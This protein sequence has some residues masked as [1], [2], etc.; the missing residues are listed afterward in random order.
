M[1]NN[2]TIGTLSAIVQ[3]K[4]NTN[5]TEYEDYLT[6]TLLIEQS[7]IHKNHLLL[8]QSGMEKNYPQIDPFML[9]IIVI[10][11]ALLFVISNMFSLSMRERVKEIGILKA[12]GGTFLKI[13]LSLISE[14]FVIGIIAVPLGAVLGILLSWIIVQIS[15]S[16]DLNICF[17]IPWIKISVVLILSFSSLIISVLATVVTSGRLPI[18]SSIYGMLIKKP[19][20]NASKLA[21]NYKKMAPALKLAFININTSKT[22]F[23]INCFAL[24]LLL[25]IYYTACYTSIA[26]SK[27]VHFRGD[28]SITLRESSLNQTEIEDLGKIDGIDFVFCPVQYARGFVELPPNQVSKPYLDWMK[29]Y[30]KNSG[31]NRYVNLQSADD[32]LKALTNPVT[33]KFEANAEIY[34]ANDK[35][36]NL[37]PVI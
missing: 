25:S 4:D 19:A 24:G 26:D 30:D 22:K 23:V 35:E 37:L 14:A 18:L 1:D 13:M 33:N 12:L 9:L 20:K 2:G 17:Q 11:A 16:S 21:N 15:S 8:Q 36:L 28:F 10:S 7:D 29:E 3:L 27:D 34:G 31:D 5:V 6:S 32:M